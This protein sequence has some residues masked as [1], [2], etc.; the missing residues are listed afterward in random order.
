MTR[1]FRCP[2]GD[3]GHVHGPANGRTPLADP[4]P[5]HVSS[6]TVMAVSDADLTARLDR[7]VDALEA[8]TKLLLALDAR[9][10]AGF[11]A[12]NGRV[13]RLSEMLTHRP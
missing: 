7:I 8:Q 5:R 2:R 11:A 10:E 9:V 4:P 13:S 3:Y 1:V 6:V 12:L